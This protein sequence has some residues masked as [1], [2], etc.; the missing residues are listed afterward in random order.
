MPP[1]LPWRPDLRWEGSRRGAELRRVL[2]PEFENKDLWPFVRRLVADAGYSLDGLAPE[3]GLR[4]GDRYARVTCA[5]LE[6]MF[7]FDLWSGAIRYGSGET[8]DPRVLADAVGAFVVGR[9]TV[10]DMSR[11]FS[12]C[13]R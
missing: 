2:Y 12:C 1:D 3:Y 9:A 13:I 11:R 7:L 4:I 5:A 10:D 8:D 6:R